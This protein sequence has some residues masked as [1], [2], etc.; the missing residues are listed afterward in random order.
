MPTLTVYQKKNNLDASMAW[1]NCR[2][3]TM[4]KIYSFAV[5]HCTSFLQDLYNL[6]DHSCYKYCDLIGQSRWYKSH[7]TLVNSHITLVIYTYRH[8]RERYR[9]ISRVHCCVLLRVRSTSNNARGNERVMFP[10]YRSLQ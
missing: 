7:K 4:F 5:Q 10:W 9:E 2:N 1:K 8:C 3:H 6:L